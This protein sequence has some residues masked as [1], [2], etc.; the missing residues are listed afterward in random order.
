MQK[1]VR[2]RPLQA[3][4][5]YSGDDTLDPVNSARIRQRSIDKL[6]IPLSAQ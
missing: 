6:S 5:A 1:I 2:I 3:R 4:R